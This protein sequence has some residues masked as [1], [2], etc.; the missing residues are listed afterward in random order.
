L[1]QGPS[2]YDVLDLT[3]N[4]EISQTYQMRFGVENVLDTDPEITNTNTAPGT[5][6]SSGQGTTIPGY[7]DVLGRRYF[8]G[9][10]ARF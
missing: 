9:F 3:G 10:K 1:F 7:Y 2:H 4:W 6:F 8:V 5:A